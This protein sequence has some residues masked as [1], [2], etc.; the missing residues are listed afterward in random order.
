MNNVDEVGMDSKFLDK[1]RRKNALMQHWLMLQTV[2]SK[3]VVTA[4]VTSMVSC[5]QSVG[6][7]HG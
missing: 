5:V 2:P 1:R 3:R 7:G 6:T 4:P